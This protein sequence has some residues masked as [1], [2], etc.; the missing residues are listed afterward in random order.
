MGKFAQAAAAA[1]ME[2]RAAYGD[3]WKEK[4]K[5]VTQTNGMDARNLTGTLRKRGCHLT[6]HEPLI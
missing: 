4:H 6:P 3:L 5:A 1:I 2:L